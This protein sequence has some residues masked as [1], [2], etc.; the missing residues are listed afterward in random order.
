[1]A[2]TVVAIIGMWKV[3]EKAGKPGWGAIIPLYNLYL[4]CKIAGRPG[5]WWVLA[6]IP[7]FG[8][9]IWF[10]L[11]LIVS[12]DIAG[13]F[14]KSGGFGIGLWLLSFVFYP[15]LGFGDAQYAGAGSA[16]AASY[17]VAAY[18]AAAYAAAPQHGQ[19]G[20]AALATGAQ[21]V[22][23]ST[24]PPWAVQPAPVATPRTP[25]TA[26]PAPQ[27]APPAPPTPP[28]APEV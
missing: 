3:F 14:G 23:P 9:L 10:I 1:L 15:I 7:I 24:P 17:G 26:P 13:T 25:Q 5:W 12:M 8:G 4:L 28:T 18:G 16:P 27:V 6:L 22:A 2:L 19:P 21:W 20:A 11:S